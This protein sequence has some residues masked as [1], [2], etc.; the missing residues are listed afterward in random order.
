MDI[1]RLS[2][3]YVLTVIPSTVSQFVQESPSPLRGRLT[4]S[5]LIPGKLLF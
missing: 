2:G 4:F 5:C 1:F 3:D